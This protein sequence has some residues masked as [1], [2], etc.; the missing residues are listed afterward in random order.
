[1]TCQFPI[2]EP[3]LD[4]LVLNCRDKNLFFTTDLEIYIRNRY[5]FYLSKYPHKNKRVGAGKASDLKW[6]EASADR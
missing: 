6:V 1:M 5:D 3:Q 2:F 4:E